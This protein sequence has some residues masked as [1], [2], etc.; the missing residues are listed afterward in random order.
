[1]RRIQARELS[2]EAFRKYGI[3]TNLYDIEEMR[4]TPPGDSGFYPD[5]MT[6]NFSAETLTSVNIS[7]IRKREN[8]AAVLEYHNRTCEGLLPLDGD[9]LIFV[10][11]ACRGFNSEV[12]EAFR[13]PCGTFVKLNPGT[14][15]G[16]QFCIDQEWVRVLILLPEGTYRNDCVKKALEIEEQVMIEF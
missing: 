12:L 11:Q 1:M 8:K 6:L 13:I 14:I 5:L 2:E 15:H 7:K 16:T 3:Y 9:C 4:K 10:G